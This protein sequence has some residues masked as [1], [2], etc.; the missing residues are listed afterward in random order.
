MTNQIQGEI[1]FKGINSGNDEWVYT[2]W[3]PVRGDIA[4]YAIEITQL[5][6]TITVTWNVETRKE[7]EPES[8]AVDIFASNQTRSTTGVGAATATVKAKQWIRYKFA[9]GSGGDATVWAMVR[10]LAPSWQVNR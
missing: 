6:G 8:T 4:T 1:L 7:E 10:A 9:T 3:M 5:G 2:P